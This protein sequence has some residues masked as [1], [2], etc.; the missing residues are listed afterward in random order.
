VGSTG[1]LINGCHLGFVILAGLFGFILA[2][3][4]IRKFI[5][6][7][8]FWATKIQMDNFVP[9][10]HRQ[11]HGR[12][13]TLLIFISIEIHKPIPIPSSAIHLAL[14][15]PL[16]N[17]NCAWWW[18]IIVLFIISRSRTGGIIVQHRQQSKRWVVV[19]MASPFRIKCYK[20]LKEQSVAK[21]IS[22]GCE[23]KDKD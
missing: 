9:Q 19:A 14:P 13:D 4:G 1:W 10:T 18:L 3:T 6:D 23:S 2:G 21:K 7:G 16:Q 5:H 20:G 22:A 15:C 8:Q 11:T 17:V 12:T